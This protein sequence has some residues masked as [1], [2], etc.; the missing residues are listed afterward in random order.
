MIANFQEYNRMNDLF[1]EKCM[2]KTSIPNRS[3]NLGCLIHF[4][5]VLQCSPLDIR[6]WDIN[7]YSNCT[8]YRV[9]D[10]V[11]SDQFSEVSSFFI[12]FV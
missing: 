7:K 2:L 8:A 6:L 4:A 9:M 12:A 5:D 11:S 3:T 1:T 10:D